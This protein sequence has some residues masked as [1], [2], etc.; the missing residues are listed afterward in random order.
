MI[1]T[2]V[3]EMVRKGESDTL[4]FKSTFDREAIE[5]LTAFANTNG[6]LLLV[7]VQDS[8]VVIGTTVGKETVQNWINQIKMA[9][10]PSIIPDVEILTVDS[11]TIVSFSLSSFPL[12]PVSCKGKYFKRN[13]ASNR[14]MTLNQVSDAYLKTFQLS[15]DSYQCTDASLEDIDVRKLDQFITK[16]N[17]IERFHLDDNHL[18]TLEK[19]RLVKDAIPTNAAMLLFSANP[20]PFNIHIGRFADVVTILDDV[21]ITD[22]LPD[23]F[24]KAMQAIAKHINI[25]FVITGSERKEVWEYPQVAV[26]EALANAIVHRDYQNPSDV[27]IK[28][29]DDRMT[30]Y[31]PGRLY[32]N[33]TVQDLLRD[34]YPS[35][36][37]NKLVAEAFYL[38]GIIEKYGSGLPRIRRVVED[39][40]NIDFSMEELPNG[41]LVTFKKRH[42]ENVGGI[43]GGIN[44]LINYIEKNPGCKAIAIAE[45]L[46]VSQRSLERILKK[47]KDDNKIVFIGAKKTGGYYL[48]GTSDESVR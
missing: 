48:A 6:G 28:I 44:Q 39:A 38:T 35:E 34:S 12:K 4:E 26:R 43:N 20:L 32:G 27:Q 25:S 2:D 9:T 18:Y 22:T 42:E 23:A 13:H 21:Q 24:S 37:R 14:L 1:I 36:L 47:L 33:L 3:A 15:W 46:K 8:G 17:R 45:V 30:I 19:L 29:F 5:T 11:K 31:S 41:F 40:G 16:V 10:M 7:G